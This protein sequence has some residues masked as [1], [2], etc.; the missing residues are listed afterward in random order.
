MNYR[1]L[2]DDEILSR[3]K[4]DERSE[5]SRWVKIE[6]SVHDK[7]KVEDAKSWSGHLLY[8]RPVTP[9]PYFNGAPIDPQPGRYI[10]GADDIPQKGDRYYAGGVWEG[11]FNYTAEKQYT[12]RESCPGD[13]VCYSRRLDESNGS[14]TDL[15]K[16]IAEA[17]K[18]LKE[19]REKLQDL[20]NCLYIGGEKIEF[21]KE[22]Y[23]KIGNI[24]IANHRIHS[25]LGFLGLADNPN[26]SHVKIDNML[27]TYPLL[28]AIAKRI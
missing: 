12:V 3:E 7:V 21:R 8:R 11:S 18:S 14:I 20:N 24:H 28:L 27:F 5:G 26:Q 2:N 1:T 22:G 23:I 19:A 9:T 13:I 16:Y 25:T 6:S 4:G 17:E 10:L 15:E